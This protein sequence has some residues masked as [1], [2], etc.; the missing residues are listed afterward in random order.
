MTSSYAQDVVLSKG[1]GSVRPD[2]YKY[3]GYYLERVFLLYSYHKSI[4]GENRK[5]FAI[6]IWE[7]L[8]DEHL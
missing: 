4:V 8:S 1:S 6:T 2:N 5:A 3:V 7:S